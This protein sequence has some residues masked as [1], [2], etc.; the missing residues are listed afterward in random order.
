MNLRELLEAR[1]TELANVTATRTADGA[2]T[3]AYGDRAFAV[4]SP[5]GAAAE[6]ALD[7][8]IAAAAGRTP[9]VEPSARGVGWV[10]FRARAL[11]DHAVDRARAWFDSAHRRLTRG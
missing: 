1:A 6:F 10:L 4:L 5:D 9:D 7:A 8:P 11:D 3:W 2:M